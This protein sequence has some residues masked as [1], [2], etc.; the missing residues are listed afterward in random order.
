VFIIHNSSVL[1]PEVRAI[2]NI[3]H[4]IQR[5]FFISSTIPAPAPILFSK[6]KKI[7]NAVFSPCYNKLTVAVGG[8]FVIF[9]FLSG[10]SKSML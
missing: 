3:H 7:I 4:F 5:S 1:V 9:L 2:L 8:L 6:Y 10:L